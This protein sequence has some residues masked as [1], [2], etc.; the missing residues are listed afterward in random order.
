M[1]VVET[2]AE[3][4]Q[5]SRNWH[6][7]GHG[8]GFVP[9]MGALH[10]G[11]M[12]LVEAARRPGDRVIASIF[13]NPLQFGA[14]EDLASYP[15]PF[16]TDRRMLAAAGVDVLFHPTV[17]EMYP[18]GADTRV[19][20]GPVAAPLEGA[21][22]PGHFA[23]VATVVARLLNAAL[24]DRAYFGQ[25]DAQQLA[26]IRALVHDLAFPVDLVACPTVRERGGLAMSS[27]NGYLDPAQRQAAL[28]LVRSLAI[29]QQAGP[30]EKA[31]RIE[32]RMAAELAAHPG[33]ELEYAAVVDPATFVRVA[34]DQA[35][36]D[37][38]LALV[39]ARVGRARLIDNAWVRGTDL[40][41]YLAQ[42]VEILSGTS[43]LAE[44][45]GISA[46]NA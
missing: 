6:A 11:H 17:E 12:S 5:L 22:R 16:E 33:V 1:K 25:K 38:G 42:P 40:A 30:G 15:R 21:S 18:L 44:S 20:P 9:T 29:A 34:P 46:W 3:L 7:R 24:P 26:V 23:G 35:A 45:K 27:R 19:T 37:A 10:A 13:V 4:Q 43:R 36:G 39:A 32:V 41:A 2:V 14:G 28:A 8:V 31:G